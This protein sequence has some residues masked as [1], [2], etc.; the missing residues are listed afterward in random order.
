MAR[1]KK[2]E[3]AG[4][5]SFTVMYVALM[6]LLLAFFI[7]MNTMATPDEARRRA[8]LS[9]LIG[10]F[11]TPQGKQLMRLLS[12]SSDPE[13]IRKTVDKQIEQQADKQI[14]KILKEIK[15][16]ANSE[17]IDFSV[18]GKNIEITI[19]SGV[20]FQPGNDEILEDI[21]PILNAV[22]E[23]IF[24]A[25]CPVI[26]EGH[27]DSA[28]IQSAR[29]PSNWELSAYRALAV[30]NYFTERQEMDP[31]KIATFGYAD[32][33]PIA[34]NDTEQNKTKNRRVHVVLLGVGAAAKTTGMKS[35]W[36][37]MGSFNPFDRLKEEY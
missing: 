29:F 6:I 23:R 16:Y 3:E 35:W 2:E 36:A 12:T 31:G 7:V 22:A 14:P 5:D 17:Y 1:R 19:N 37:R 25:E 4:G 21:Y 18:A 10:T 34:P 33:H 32:L 27:T 11:G 15:R 13:E 24:M 30:Q 26:I 28:P 8:A 9:S 20:M